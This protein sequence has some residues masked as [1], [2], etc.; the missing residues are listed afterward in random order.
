MTTITADYQRDHE[1]DA[2]EAA[3]LLIEHAVREI[4]KVS[5]TRLPSDVATFA[6]QEL[7]AAVGQFVDEQER[8]NNGRTD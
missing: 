5:L 4:E 2:R 8:V 6:T 1:R 3:H 7:M